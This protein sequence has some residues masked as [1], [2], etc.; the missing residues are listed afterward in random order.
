MLNHEGKSQARG[1]Q[2]PLIRSVDGKMPCIKDQNH[3]NFQDKRY[4]KVKSLKS[5]NQD[6][7][8]CM[9]VY[10][11]QVASPKP[12]KTLARVAGSS[13]SKQKQAKVKAQMRQS[14]LFAYHS[15]QLDKIKQKL[16]S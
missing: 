11:Q 5:L 3:F 12:A 6:M 10:E 2:S 1:T 15:K 16:Q 8:I 4:A 7:S 14:R 13:T 9:Q